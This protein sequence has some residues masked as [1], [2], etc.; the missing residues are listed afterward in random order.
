[1]IGTA[2]AILGAVA[3]IHGISRCVSHLIFGD[4]QKES[5]KQI[6]TDMK[7]TKVHI[8]KLSENIL[9][10]V[11]LDGVQAT[12]QKQQQYIN[13]LREV[14]QLLEPLQQSLKQP[15]LSSSIIGAPDQIVSSPP[16]QLLR[17][18]SRLEYVIRPRVKNWEPV[19]FQDK[20]KC[21]VG[22][23]SPQ[24]LGCQSYEIWPFNQ[25]TLPESQL[26]ESH[27]LD[28]TTFLPKS[29]KT[30]GK[31]FSDL[32]TDGTEG[33]EMV[34]IPAG[35]FTMGDIQGTG[36][37]SEKPVH[38]VS[39]KSFAIG[40]YPV[41]FAEYDYFCKAT[42]R[43]KPDNRGWGRYKRPVMNISWK[44]AVA[45]T[46]WLSKQ[47]GNTYRL[48]SEAQ[49]E[50]AARAGT[51]TDYWWGNDIG[52]NQANCYLS[53][54]QWSD[55]QTSPVG[56]FKPNP[57]GLYDT[58]GN[59]WEWCVDSWH[60]N[61]QNAP[62]DGSVWNNNKKTNEYKVLRG[63]SW[64]NNPINARAANRYRH[65]PDIRLNFLGF[66]VVALTFSH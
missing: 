37:A 54:S 66:R 31:V 55:I 51:E 61:Y 15:I 24:Q 48:P 20:G 60:E 59:V 5:L 16:R 53:G 21:Y 29:Q 32:L 58:V 64:S 36:E 33:P 19:L 44:D 17:D 14:R 1:M 3:D 62:T 35:K 38:E 30:I 4:K 41:T 18:I 9:Y 39:I 52:I 13:E 46:D 10:A 8:E 25:N 22:W 65:K 50:Y 56:S 12:Q 23:Q 6:A 47:T 7:D 45:Y 11:N 34:M 42:N 27:P 26:S 28:I 43:E 49:W 57:F 2:I 63:G 40:R